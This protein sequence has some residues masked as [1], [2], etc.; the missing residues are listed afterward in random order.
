L[1]TTEVEIPELES[2]KIKTEETMFEVKS[3]LVDKVIDKKLINLENIL[4]T[5]DSSKIPVDDFH[6]ELSTHVDKVMS[7]LPG[8]DEEENKSIAYVSKLICSLITE[9]HIKQ[10]SPIPPSTPILKYKVKK[11]EDENLELSYDLLT[12][13]SYMRAVR[14]KLNDK[15]SDFIINKSRFYLQMRCYLDVFCFSFLE[16]ADKDQLLSI[17]M[18]RF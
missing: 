5:I 14:N 8:L 18:N 4:T 9:S 13:F 2:K 7:F 15:T 1:K 16:K 3:I 10:N 6:Q 11:I 12:M 17:V